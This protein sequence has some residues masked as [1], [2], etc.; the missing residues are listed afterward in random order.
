MIIPKPIE[1]YLEKSGFIAALR[2]GHYFDKFV[3]SFKEH[4]LPTEEIFEYEKV[5]LYRKRNFIEV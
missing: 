5:C 1:E 4:N 3:R 2:S